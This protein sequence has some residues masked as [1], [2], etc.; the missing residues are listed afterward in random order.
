MTAVFDNC[1]G[2]EY[3]CEYNPAK[4]IRVG[5]DKHGWGPYADDTAGDGTG[6]HWPTYRWKDSCHDWWPLRDT[7]FP[8]VVDVRRFM[9]WERRF[10]LSEDLLHGQPG[11]YQV[12]LEL[13]SRFADENYVDGY[14]KTC[15]VSDPM[16]VWFNPTQLDPTPDCEEMP[17]VFPSDY[18]LY[19]HLPGYEGRTH[20][21]V[22]NTE[23][24]VE[25]RIEWS[26]GSLWCKFS[27]PYT[28]EQMHADIED[29]LKHYSFDDVPEDYTR[30]VT[31]GSI[32]PDIGVLEYSDGSGIVPSEGTRFE[33]GIG[34]RLVFYR[35]ALNQLGY[36]NAQA[37]EFLRTGSCA[38]I[39]M[40]VV[41]ANCPCP[42]SSWDGSPP[43][44]APTHWSVT[45][46]VTLLNPPERIRIYPLTGT[47]SEKYFTSCPCTPPPITTIGFTA[48]ATQI[49]ADSTTRTADETGEAP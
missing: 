11:W 38:Q 14:T 8:T 34:A 23:D 37:V 27:N 32:A 46:C 31:R 6:T 43:A 13:T 19:N 49:L 12:T 5:L 17:V 45:D 21:L 28:D 24:E 16:W 41:T 47:F 35:D 48:D 22:S 33:W 26:G 25:W 44:P 2:C 10:E 30:T 29:L 7:T 18:W 4:A 3:G 36:Y 20:T 39:C 1:C 15:S 42:P 9:T 40:N